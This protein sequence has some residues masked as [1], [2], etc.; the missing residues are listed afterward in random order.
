MRSADT[1]DLLG[2]QGFD[3]VANTPAEFTAWIRS[4][5]AKWSRVIKASGATAD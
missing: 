1:R 3:V 2:K 5:Q 4:E